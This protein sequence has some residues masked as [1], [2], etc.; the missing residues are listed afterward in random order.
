M[1]L[2]SKSPRFT[3]NGKSFSYFSSARKRKILQNLLKH[4]FFPLFFGAE[5]HFGQVTQ[6]VNSSTN[7]P[8]FIVFVKN[9]LDLPLVDELTLNKANILM[10]FFSLCK[11]NF[12][13]A[14]EEK[15]ID[16]TFISQI[17]K[18]LAPWDRDYLFFCKIESYRVSQQVPHCLK[19][20]QNVSFKKIQ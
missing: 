20:S 14:G 6:R 12:W 13:C 8:Y 10:I 2:E 9:Y 16:L 3:R 17:R 11:E 7:G 19:I 15:F 5:H 1:P 4:W 18:K